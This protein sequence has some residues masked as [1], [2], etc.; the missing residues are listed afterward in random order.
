MASAIRFR[1][2]GDPSSKVLRTRFAPS[3]TGHLHVGGAR[4]ALFC[5][6][7]ARA[8][9]GTFILR[10]EDTDRRRSSDAAAQAILE[11]LK[12]LDIR[13]DEGPEYDGWGGG[14]SGPYHQSQ[15]VDLYRRY[16]EQLIEKGDAYR[17][18][19]TPEEL[20]AAR[21]ATQAG[22]GGYRYDRA[23]LRLDDDTIRR[24]LGENRPYVVRFKVPD[25]GE[26]TV[27]DE[28]RG[29]V[30]VS[31]DELDDFVILKADGYPTYH[32]AVVVDDELMG[33][34]HVIR[35]QEHLY[36]T[37]RH[38]LLQDALGF[39]RPAYAHISLILNPDGSKMSKRDRDKALRRQVRHRRLEDAPPGSDVSPDTWR[40]WIGDEDHQ[41]DLEASKR[42][43]QALAV[44][45]PEI[46]LEDFRR[47][48]YLPEV[49]VNYLALLGWSPGGGREKFDRDFLKAN[50][51]LDRIIKSPARFDRDK[52]LAFNLDGLQAMPA[53]VFEPRLREHGERYHRDYLQKLGDDKFAA[54][55]AANHERSKTL[56]DP[57]RTCRF[58]VA[59]DDEIVY[60]RSKAVRKA[61][62]KGEPNGYARLEA[63]LPRLVALEG[64][65]VESLEATVTAFV[66]EHVDGKLG[67]VAQPLRI[68]VS[69][70]TISPAI[71]DTLAILGRQ[72]VLNRIERCLAT[73]QQQEQP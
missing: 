21:A 2:M 38:V 4:T 26:I 71:F 62:E 51:S 16:A 55:A 48:G 5:W 73:R 46:D 44:A 22:G 7:L 53:D 65:T 45:L 41:L 1:L 69:G 14:D 15:R 40:W 23:S 70:G 68:A 35:G 43:A 9:G 47:A 31:A 12:W 67:K 32:F 56:E 59:E 28:V 18:F 27:H 17:A 10:V 49:L 61:L 42:L 37:P 13:W 11:D 34:T 6:A 50:F 39:R 36:N 72:S 33:V 64:W 54:F 58:F 52:L 66:D 30:R 20:D 29:E 3:P 25:E 60:E 63:V 8:G 19:E 24:Y 57:Y